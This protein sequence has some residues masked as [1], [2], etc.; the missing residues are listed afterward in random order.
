MSKA[1]RERARERRREQRPSQPLARPPFFPAVHPS[2]LPLLSLPVAMLAM[3]LRS[4]LR[5]AP[6]VLRRPA[7]S[8]PS[9]SAAVAEEPAAVMMDTFGRFHDYLRISLTE[10]CNLRCTPQ[11]HTHTHT[12]THAPCSVLPLSLIDKRLNRAALFS[13]SMLLSLSLFPPLF[14]CAYSAAHEPF[15]AAHA[16]LVFLSL[17]FLSPPLSTLPLFQASLLSPSPLLPPLFSLPGRS[18]P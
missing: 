12:H 8:A 9:P 6:R 15:A 17:G 16:P 2:S 5:S 11:S 4:T 14:H 3:R 7:L 18:P 13:S 1:Q 10:R